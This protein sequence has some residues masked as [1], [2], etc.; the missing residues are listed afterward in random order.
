MYALD[1]KMILNGTYKAK[2]FADTLTR[3]HVVFI[4]NP[5]NNIDGLD[6]VDLSA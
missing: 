6:K 5:L 3:R 4:N 1:L 2:A